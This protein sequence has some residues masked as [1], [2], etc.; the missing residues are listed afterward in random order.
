MR[1]DPRLHLQPGV[2]IE[3]GTELPLRADQAHYLGTVMRRAPGDGVVLFNERDGEW[4]GRLHAI[5]RDRAAVLVEERLR[6]PVPEPGPVLLF[7]PI[8]RDPTDL[9]I[10]MATE[11]GARAFWPVQTERTNTP[12]INAD[13]LAAIAREAAE[14]CERLSVPPV[15]PLCRLGEA[16][17]RWSARNGAPRLLAAIEPWHADGRA[18]PPIRDWRAAAGTDDAAGLGVLIGPEGGFTPA[19]LDA[20]RRRSFVVPVSLGPRVLR[21][22]TAAA[23]A[24]ASLIG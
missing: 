2:P 6:P 14:Q 9:M 24:L 13:R 5:R 19:E 23:A 3:P 16:L 4:R 12:R 10:R 18:A 20:L 21:A 15:E 22:D 1:D 11:L 8:K 17:D 7:A